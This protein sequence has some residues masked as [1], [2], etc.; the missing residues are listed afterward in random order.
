MNQDQEGLA[1]QAYFVPPPL[2]ELNKLYYQQFSN[3]DDPVHHST[4]FYMSYN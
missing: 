2:N 3:E 4:K 1:E